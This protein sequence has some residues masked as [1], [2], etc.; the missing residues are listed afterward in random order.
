MASEPH[1]TSSLDL[2]ASYDRIVCTKTFQGDYTDLLAKIGG[3]DLGADAEEEY[4]TEI[5]AAWPMS[6]YADA[7]HIRILDARMSRAQAGRGQLTMTIAGIRN[8]CVWGLDFTEVSK[9]IRT[10]HQDEEDESKKPVLSIISAWEALK[11][12]TANIQNYQQFKYYDG[13][14][15][16]EIEKDSP[17]RKLATMMYHGIESYSIHIPVISCQA[18]SVSLEDITPECWGSVGE[19]LSKENVPEDPPVFDHLSDADCA[20][21]LE[22]VGKN[23]DGKDR[24]WLMTADRLTINGDG[25]FVRNLQ[26]TG[27]DFIEP[28]LYEKVGG[29]EE[30]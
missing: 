9:D 14:S 19:N 2:S 26:W 30:E 25:T 1:E 11:G 23:K 17:T 16:K 28:L 15:L 22:G 27:L 12:D 5:R 8:L 13:S 3:L 7:S 21:I 29:G 6:W 4:Q 24:E 18:T 20:T 10:W